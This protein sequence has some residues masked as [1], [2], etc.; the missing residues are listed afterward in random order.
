MK[1]AIIVLILISLCISVWAQCPTGNVSF[2]SQTQINSFAADYPG[3]TDLP[4][5]LRVEDSGISITN[6]NGLSQLTS[7]GGN[8][9]IRSNPN[10]YNLSG[11]SNLTSIGDY[12]YVRFNDDLQNFN[13]LNSLTTIGGYMLVQWNASLSSVSGLNNLTS[14][15]GD[16]DFYRNG[17]LSSFAAFS[18]LTSV[19]GSLEVEDNDN[20]YSLN[21]LDNIDANG[22]TFIRIG[23]NGNLSVCGVESICTYLAINGGGNI[24]GNSSG[25]SNGAEVAASSNCIALTSCPSGDVTLTTQQEVDDFAVNYPN[26]TE[27]VGHLVISPYFDGFPADIVD[28]SPLSQIVSVGGFLRI[29]G[30]DMLTNLTGLEGIISIGEDIAIYNNNNLTDLNGL[31]NITSV[32]HDIAIYNNAVLSDLMGLDNV[33]YTTIDNLYINDNPQLATCNIESICDYLENGGTVTINNNAPGCNSQAQ[34]EA[35]CTPVVI[36]PDYFSPTTQQQI[37]DFPSNY[38]NCTAVGHLDLHFP[39]NITNLDSL[40][41]LTSVTD[42]VEIGFFEPNNIADISG[43]QNITSIGSYLQIT[44]TQ[45]TDLSGFQNLTS[46]GDYVTIAVNPNL[47]T[48]SGLENLDAATLENMSIGSNDNLSICNLTNICTHLTDG[49]T[50]DFSSNALGCD[51][52]AQVETTCSPVTV[53]PDNLFLTSQQDVDD[54]PT[55]Y[56]GCLEISGNVYI[57]MDFI[58]NLDGLSQIAAIRGNLIMDVLNSAPSDFTADISGLQNLTIVDGNLNISTGGYWTNPNLNGLQNLTSVGGGLYFF[59]NGFTDLSPLQNLTSINGSLIISDEYITSLDAL[60]NIDYTGITDL[61]LSG[62]GNLS[63]CHLP[64]I[65]AYLENGGTSNISGNAT[66]CATQAE[67]EYRC[68][69]ET[70]CP[71]YFFPSSQQEIDNFPSNYP[72]CTTIGYLDLSFTFDITNLDSLAQLTSISGGIEINTGIYSS[73]TDMSGLQNLTSIGGSLYL[74]YTEIADL[75]GL[76]NVTSIGGKISLIGNSNLLSLDG[77]ENISPDSIGGLSIYNN[78]N[79]SVCSLPNICTYLN[80]GL[81]NST[82]ISGNSSGC[83]SEA[84]VQADC[85]PT[86]PDNPCDGTVS[87]DSLSHIFDE[88]LFIDGVGFENNPTITFPAPNANAVLSDISLELYFRLNGNTCENEIAL[89]VTDPAGNTQPLTA[90]TTCDGGTDLYYVNLDVPS[91]NSGTGDWLV[92]FDDTNDQN[93]DY[94]YSVRFARLNYVATTG[95]GSGESVV[96]EVSQIA[97]NDLFIDGVGFANNG[98]YTFSDSGTPADAVLSDISLELYFRINGASCENEIAIQITDPAGNTQALTAYA[99][100]DGGTGLYYVDLDVPS[101]N[102]T[103]SAA[104]WVVQF[105]DTN[106]QNSDYEYSVRFGRLT[107]TTTHTGG[108]GT[109]VIIT[110]EVVRTA[111]SD[112]FIDGVGFDNN[113]TYTFYDPATPEIATLSDISLELYFRLNG[114]S[115]ENE[116]AI[117]LT[118]PAGN[119]QA[120]TTYMTCDGG[121]ELYY[122]N[123]NV[124]SGSVTGEIAPWI[125]QFDDTNDQNSDYEY[126]VRFGRLTYTTQYDLCDT[127]MMV[128]EE[129]ED[130]H[131]LNTSARS[132]YNTTTPQHHNTLKLYP[133]PASQHLNVEYF[134]E[135]NN[136]TNIEIISNEGKTLMSQKEFSQEGINTIQLDIADL[137]AGHYHIRMYNAEDMQMQ[138]FVKIMP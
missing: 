23:G 61:Y 68:L 123:L 58:D 127:Q 53:C 74:L 94:E 32:E 3:C 85:S 37:D 92:E 46:V 16:M 137:P 38:P 73:L 63:Y 112:L 72:Y 75:S 18:N 90:Y 117:Q 8:L 103:G 33:E 78:E 107:Y 41:Q 21:G 1:K 122:V 43:L 25:C 116:I 40:I 95:G 105:D 106:D 45:L 132:N 100:C 128:V 50:V 108:G 48:L 131:Q 12:F 6:L 124:P 82:N 138:S 27:I 114:A 39:G 129:N 87:T 11:L 60:E 104:D 89:Q 76:Q 19:N 80:E 118:D 55:S 5:S 9:S 44:G 130:S 77:L 121:T 29:N 15:G 81:G 57:A 83:N 51:T 135:N 96:N 71:D 59:G 54:V 52:Q 22:L 20:L 34:I 67:V 13:G 70:A 36:C 125:V 66:G 42:Y 10:L 98:N 109:P 65:C 115:C 93:S 111:D 69:S 7:I 56:P 28:L 30:N 113:Q 64:N 17:S 47:T 62:N 97:D 88:D 119:T 110:D 31:V 136:P 102:T 35:A 101:G 24:Y 133:V 2:T 86:P 91:G 26:C 84:E 49:G 120:L 4:G 126:S 99:S 134:S 79:L 14:I